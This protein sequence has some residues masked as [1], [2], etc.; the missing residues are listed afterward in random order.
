MYVYHACMCG[1]VIEIKCRTTHS[2]YNY[3]SVA[4]R[5]GHSLNDGVAMCMCAAAL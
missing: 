2:I 1:C 4:V 3:W 5:G